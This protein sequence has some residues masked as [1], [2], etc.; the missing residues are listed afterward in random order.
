MLFFPRWFCSFRSFILVDLHFSD[1]FVALG[2][3]CW[4]ISPSD[5]EAC[6]CPDHSSILLLFQKACSVSIVC[7]GFRSFLLVDLQCGTIERMM[8]T[9]GHHQYYLLLLLNC[10]VLSVVRASA[11]GLWLRSSR[12]R[13]RN[14]YSSE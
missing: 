10:F 2:H 11:I 9:Y 13:V 5:L 12:I 4:L 6:L 14:L 3:S 7:L 8:T 1:G